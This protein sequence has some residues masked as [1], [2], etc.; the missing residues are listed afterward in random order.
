MIGVN[1]FTRTRNCFLDGKV[2]L[3][4]LYLHGEVLKEGGVQL[5]DQREKKKA[6]CTPDLSLKTISR[7]RH[8]QTRRQRLFMT[9]CWNEQR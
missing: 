4:L 7:C 5:E 2:L 6:R 3:Y 1:R 8:K 9:E